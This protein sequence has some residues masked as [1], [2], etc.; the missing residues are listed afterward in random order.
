MAYVPSLRE[1][2]IDQYP[3]VANDL[4]P[5][6][7]E[8]PGDGEIDFSELTEE[9]TAHLQQCPTCASL[10]GYDRAGLIG[11]GLVGEVG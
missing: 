5:D 11:E 4:L 10:T 6:F 2:P 9:Q 8:S 1:I 3:H 7:S